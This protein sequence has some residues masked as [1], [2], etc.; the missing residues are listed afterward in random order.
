MRIKKVR[1]ELSNPGRRREQG[2]GEEIS[3]CLF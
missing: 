1:Q 3:L 2:R